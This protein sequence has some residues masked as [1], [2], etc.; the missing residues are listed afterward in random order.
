MNTFDPY[1]EY[2]KR[3]I[4]FIMEREYLCYKMNR[5]ELDKW[6]DLIT[7][8]KTSFYSIADSTE[9]PKPVFVDVLDRTLV[10][11]KPG[12]GARGYIRNHGF[13]HVEE[14]DRGALTLH[15]SGC[16]Y[17]EAKNDLVEK[18]A[19]DI[20]LEYV[21]Q[22]RER[23]QGKY[24]KQWRYRR[25]EDG[26]EKV[27]G[28]TIAK[29]HLEEQGNWIYNREYDYRKYWFELLLFMVKRILDNKAYEHNVAYYEQCMNHHEKI[30]TFN[31]KTEMFEMIN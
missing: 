29:S 16:S 18:C 8:V 3:G 23:L 22:N 4:A 12:V 26:I 1:D 15:Y 14:G 31:H 19:W 28:L 30:W 5:D 20:S 6:E 7:D 9:I 27:N 10:A 2:E 21:T 13:Y 11:Y 17:E 25:V 24:I